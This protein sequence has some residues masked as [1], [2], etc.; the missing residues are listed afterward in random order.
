MKN[1]FARVL[2]SSFAVLIT[3][4]LLPHVKVE[5]W[6]AALMLAIVLA[7]LNA[8]LKPILV[9]LT[10]PVTVLSLGLFL[11]VINTGIIVFADYLL[12]EFHVDNYFWALMFSLIL[13]IVNSILE[14]IL[15]TNQKEDE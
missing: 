11:L 15:G 14:G 8:F 13:S 5:N 3:A 1:W 7:F 12:D 9:I 2:V 4:Y 6:P 10:L